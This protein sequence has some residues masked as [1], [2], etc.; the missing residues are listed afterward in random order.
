M[1]LRA[2]DTTVKFMKFLALYDFFRNIHHV[3]SFKMCYTYR[4]SVCRL[5]A[6]C[7]VVWHCA[8]EVIV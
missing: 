1:S 4:K 8:V 7:A 3:Q 6:S 5:A 2:G